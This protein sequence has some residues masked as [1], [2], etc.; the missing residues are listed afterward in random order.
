MRLKFGFFEKI[1]LSLLQALMAM[2]WLII[3][4]NGVQVAMAQWISHGP[5]G[6]WSR[7]VPLVFSTS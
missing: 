6:G 7:A 5:Y 2:V 3:I 4:L 1:G